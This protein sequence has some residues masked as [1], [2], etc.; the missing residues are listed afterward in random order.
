MKDRVAQT[1]GSQRQVAILLGAFAVAALLLATLGIFGLVS[2]TTSQRSRELAIRMALGSSSRSVVGLVFGSG[3]RLLAMGLVLGLAGAALVG[4][5]L[6]SRLAGI[7]AFDAPLYA[8]IA[9]ILAVAGM[10][11]CIAPAFRAVRIPP[12]N[13]LRYE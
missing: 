10:A 5:L 7:S 1:I 6:A 9:V 11:A 12:A 2:Y 8:V 13:A 3:M 4:H